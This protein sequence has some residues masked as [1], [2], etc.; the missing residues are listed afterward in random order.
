MGGGDGSAPQLG[1]GRPPNRGGPSPK[2]LFAFP[3]TEED[4][5]KQGNEMVERIT[6]FVS[7][8][9]AEGFEARCG[10]AVLGRV[11]GAFPRLAAAL[12]DAGVPVDCVEGVWVVPPF[13][14]SGLPHPARWHEVRARLGPFL[15]N[16]LWRRIDAEARGGA[17]VDWTKMGL[18]PENLVVVMHR[19]RWREIGGSL[20]QQATW[21]AARSVALSFYRGAT[22]ERLRGL[23]VSAWPFR[24]SWLFAWLLIDLAVC[25]SYAATASIVPVLWNDVLVLVLANVMLIGYAM[26]ARSEADTALADAASFKTAGSVALRRG[27]LEIARQQYLEGDTCA[28]PAPRADSPAPA[29]APAIGNSP[30]PSPSPS[31]MPTPRAGSRALL[32]PL[33]QVRRQARYDGPAQ[34]SVRRARHRAARRVPQQCGDRACAAPGPSMK[35][36]RGPICDDAPG[37]LTGTPQGEGVGTCC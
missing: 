23:A 15:K 3:D 8:V 25:A 6:R 36:S 9:R 20:W 37:A 14:V 29:P 22:R 11:E 17:A 5:L 33:A 27:Q 12:A 10:A 19:R 30:S 32:L 34:R 26:R 31:F 13:I 16:N 4:F 2:G 28:P 21:A 35:L 24:W 18:Q 1:S 7:M